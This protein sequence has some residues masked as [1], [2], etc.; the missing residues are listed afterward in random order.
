LYSNR[1]SPGL[2][3]GDIFGEISFPYLGATLKSTATS[4][5]LVEP[6]AVLPEEVVVPCQR[7]YVVVVSHDCEFNEDKRNRLLVARIEAV[8]KNLSLEQ[9]EDLR[10][11][12]DVRARAEAKKTI[13]GVDSFLLAAVPGAFPD[14][15]I[16]VFTTITPL[17]MKMK[18]EFVAVK[19]AEMEHDH[20]VL[21]RDKL[22]WF[23]GRSADDISDDEKSDAPPAGTG[24]DEPG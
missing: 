11:S 3:Q 2:R 15:R 13:A 24:A 21:F 9:V 20:R 19:R 23:F 1:W 5:S 18:G 10:E 7:R 12:N 4:G 22:A 6:I 14:E 16:A 8:P 17:S